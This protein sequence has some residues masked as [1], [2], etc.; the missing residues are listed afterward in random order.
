ML[1]LADLFRVHADKCIRTALNW[2]DLKE[3]QT[4]LALAQERVRAATALEEAVRGCAQSI[5]AA[6]TVHSHSRIIR[7]YPS[8]TRKS[9]PAPRQLGLDR[10]PGLATTRNGC[11]GHDR[12]ES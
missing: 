4:L 6:E 3:V 5:D 12:N 11:A 10:R 2:R 9:R 8:A 7:I 1:S